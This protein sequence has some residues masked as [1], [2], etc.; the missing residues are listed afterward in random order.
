VCAI[1]GVVLLVLWGG[2]PASAGAALLVAI[3]GAYIAQARR[4][5]PPAGV[6]FAALHIA[7]QL[8]S[9]KFKS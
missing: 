9:A 5:G 2:L 4:P 1:A 8:T 3:H 7:A 6:L